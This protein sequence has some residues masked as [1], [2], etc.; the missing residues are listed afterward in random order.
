MEVTLLAFATAAERLG[1][2]TRGV[3]AEPDNTPLELFRSVDGDFSPGTARVAVN[4]QYHD[5]TAA[6]G[7]E[8][9]EVAMIPPV[10]GG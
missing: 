7:S 10:S 1:W 2:R 3:V 5:W 6:I 4:G 8:A 9:R